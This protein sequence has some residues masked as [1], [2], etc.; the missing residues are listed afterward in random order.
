MQG[1]AVAIVCLALAALLLLFPST[2]F[3]HWI[4]R[5]IGYLFDP[6]R[7]APR[8]WEFKAGIFF[9]LVG[10]AIAILKWRNS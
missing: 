6:R 7:N 1:I 10:L 2:D 5:Q 4:G 9:A 3:A 8:E